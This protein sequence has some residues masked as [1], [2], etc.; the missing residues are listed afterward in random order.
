M[1]LLG[2]SV[3]LDAAVVLEGGVDDAT[4]ELLSQ[5][6]LYL[7]VW[8]PRTVVVPGT[9]KAAR[10]M[11]HAEFRATPR[12]TDVALALGWSDA[13]SAEV[14]E[15]ETRPPHDVVDA[16]DARGRLLWRRRA[17]SL[18]AEAVASMAGAEREGVDQQ[19]LDL[20]VQVA[21]PMAEVGSFNGLREHQWFSSMVVGTCP[22]VEAWLVLSEFVRVRTDGTYEDVSPSEGAVAAEVAARYFTARPG[23][24]WQGISPRFGAVE[25]VSE[26]LGVR[27]FS[28]VVAPAFR[29]WID[30]AVPR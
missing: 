3:L 20:G 6:H 19:F 23:A 10:G 25:L 22:D 29:H 12:G 18:L 13:R 16:L 14:R 7:V 5:F 26:S 11:F 1:D 28:K 15:F 27:L 24:A 4:A 2:R 17:S 9:L 30:P 8:R 21:G